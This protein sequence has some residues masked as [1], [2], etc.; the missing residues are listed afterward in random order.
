MIICVSFVQVHYG[1]ASLSSLSRLPAYFVFRQSPLDTAACTCQL[2]RHAVDA[3]AEGWAA[4]LVRCCTQDPTVQTSRLTRDT[5]GHTE[6]CWPLFQVL[7]DQPHAHAAAA[8]QQCL[9]EARGGHD[10]GAAPIILAETRAGPLDPASGRPAIPR[11][12][13]GAQSTCACR[14]DEVGCTR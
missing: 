9:A 14:A 1:P 4:V 10:A 7:L 13:G 8:L 6:A 3:G 2:L 5:N 11:E 12:R